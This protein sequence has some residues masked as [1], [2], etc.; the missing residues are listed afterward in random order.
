MTSKKKVN[1]SCIIK[2]SETSEESG[3]S[4]T[5][6]ESKSFMRI[7]RLDAESARKRKEKREYVRISVYGSVK[8]SIVYSSRFLFSFPWCLSLIGFTRR[9]KSVFNGDHRSFEGHTDSFQ[10][11]FK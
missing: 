6:T 3:A 1:R 7:L 2:T 9:F 4:Q 8:F 5:E 11:R 10:Q